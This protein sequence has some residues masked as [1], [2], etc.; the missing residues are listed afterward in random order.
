MSMPKKGDKAPDFK[1]LNQNNET[2]QL[3]D[4]KGKKLALYFYPQDNTPTC[5]TEACNLRDNYSSLKAA[6]FEI[7]G[8]SPDSAQKHQ[9]FIKKHELP[10]DLLVDSDKSIHEKYGVWAEKTRFGKT[11]IG[12]LR[13]T[14]IIDENGVIEEVIDKVKSKEHHLQLL[15]K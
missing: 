14:F 13:T 7:L 5:T 4:F 8:V 15:G 9:N 3:S 10:F 11:Y 1:A 6:G 12:T 2:V